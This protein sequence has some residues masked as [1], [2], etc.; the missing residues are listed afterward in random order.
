MQDTKLNGLGSVEFLPLTFR[1]LQSWRKNILKGRKCRFSCHQIVFT[2]KDVRRGTYSI[3]IS[4]S[5]WYL[6]FCICTI[7]HVLKAPWWVFSELLWK[8]I[9]LLLPAY[10]ALRVEIYLGRKSMAQNISPISTISTEYKLSGIYEMRETIFY[11]EQWDRRDRDWAAHVGIQ[12]YIRH[13]GLDNCT[14]R[15]HTYSQSLFSAYLNGELGE[16]YVLL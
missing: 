1:I 3:L 6:T 15:N 14:K 11:V 10:R 8:V 9:Y 12:F 4:V 16:N 13:F 7:S 5:S 2:C